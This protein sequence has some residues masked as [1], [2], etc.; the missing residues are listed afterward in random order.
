MTKTA[1]CVCH[2]TNER[3]CE[4]I[5]Q[6]G[7]LLT[8]TVLLFVAEGGGMSLWDTMYMCG[9]ENARFVSVGFFTIMLRM[10]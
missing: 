7:S 10:L 9:V 3:E 2:T 6:N 1:H 4:C 8:F 5:V